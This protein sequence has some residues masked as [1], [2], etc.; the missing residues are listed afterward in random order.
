MVEKKKEFKTRKKAYN[1]ARRK[2][3]RPWKGLSIFSG[4]IALILVPVLVILTM[5]DNT[6][7]AF[8]GGTFW[9]LENEDESAVYYEADFDTAEEMNAYGLKICEQVEAE[10]AAL[11]MN[12]DNALPLDKN[13]KVSCFSNS[14]TNL[15]Y[16]GT[17]SGNIDASKADNLKTALEKTGFE[18]NETLWNFYAEGDGAEYKRENGGMV[19]TASAVVSEVP[20]NVYTDEVKDSVAS[21]GDAAIVTFSRVGGE[22]A[23]LEF[24]ETNYLALDDNEKE[25]MENISAMKADGTISKIIVL[26]NSANTLQVD[27]LKDNVYDVDA[28]L[29]I[30]DVGIS[31]INAVA[32]ILCGDATPSGSL[33]DTYLYDNYSSPAMINYVP[34]TYE[35][36]TKGVIPANASTYMIYQEGIYVGYKYYETRYDDYVT[37]SGNAGDYAYHDDV[38]YPFGYGLSYTDFAFSNMSVSY[39]EAEDTFDVSVTVT[40]TGDTFAGKKTVQVYSQSPYTDYDMENGVEKA[41]VSLCGF[42]KTDILAPGESQ[43]LTV[44]VDKRDLASYD[45]YEAGTY[46]LDAG[47]YYLTVGMDAHDAVNNTLAARGYTPENTDERMDEAGEASL[48]YKWTQETFDAETYSVSENG[49]KIENQLSGADI[50]LYEGTDEEI[51]YLSRRDWEGTFPAESLKLTLTEQMIE[52]LQDVQYDPAD[53][54]E[55][56]MPTLGADNGLTLYDMKDLDFDDPK[57]EE[58]LDQLT[59][60]E[61]VTM[62]GDA[63][64][65]TMPVKSVEA[66]G[67]RD[68]NGPQGLTAS[69]LASD[70]TQMD[71][72]AFTSED[73]MAATFNVDL[74]TEVG[75]VIGNNCI[76]AGVSCLYGP[77]NN[78]HR[79][80]F[81]G[82]NFEYYSED[83]FLS[84]KMSAYEVGAI[85]EKGIN[86]VMKHFALNDSEQDRIG[87]GVWVNEQAAR[88][89]YLKA[90]QDVVE[91]GNAN[92]VMTAYTR[93]GCIW[94]GGNRG[95]MTNILRDEWGCWGKNITDN[96]LTSY[97]NGVDGLMAGVTIFD[98]MMP[99]VTSQL[100]KY[101]DD[102]VIVTAMREASHY[103]LY[104]TLNS[105]GMNGVGPDT[106]VKLTDLKVLVI[107]RVVLT[108]FALLFVA[109]VVMWILGKRKF[110]K[111]E[112][113]KSFKEY[114]K[115]YKLE[116]KSP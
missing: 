69:L 57:W 41:A 33:V 112:I 26:I 84:G 111:T 20:W 70:K 32:D 73:M 105:A 72:T 64:H 68:E 22:G 88:E 83:G 104:A 45:T 102:P 103:N 14:S 99:F 16:G 86:V 81:G 36:Y 6:V 101:E 109:S 30:G 116:K 24:E 80:P 35:G 42:A 21:Y 71:A 19:S 38:A 89:I 52:D 11:L 63:F 12:E 34:M 9:E 82:R 54:D 67:T 37:G 59:F 94:S 1:K 108:V 55:V 47:D 56:E 15:V 18:V 40:N 3:I 79:T 93:W 5:F 87:L 96:V 27:F 76:F 7:A 110:K 25:M 91:E 60:D 44:K 106:T 65:W 4:I 13:A 98:A 39:N 90:F 66:P 10:G 100:P 23:D 43:T 17:G 49:T 95:L 29:W 31:G 28:C 113:C 92:G 48:T 97:V 51:L 115:A 107:L 46:I 75:K 77:G 50:N 61:M 85:Q 62:I 114:K 78:I 53:Y 58:L 74:M 2:T 8:V